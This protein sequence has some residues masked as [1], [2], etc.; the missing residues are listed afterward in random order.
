M[1]TKL[2]AL[3]FLAGGSMF[4]QTRFSVGINVGSYGRD[5]YA[6]ASPYAYAQPPR[7]G[8]DYSWIDGYWSQDRGRRV[9]VPGYWARP[10]YNRYQ[11][12]SHYEQHRD[13]YRDRD[14]DDDHDRRY[15]YESGFRGR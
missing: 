5:T 2:L 11:S 14:R 13:F 4:A 3:A 10:L 12:E 7:P 15:G 6:Q 1:K 8:P 9:W